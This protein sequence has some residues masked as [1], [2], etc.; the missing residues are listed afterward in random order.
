MFVESAIN[1]WKREL[2]VWI[3]I[4]FSVSYPD[5]GS[6]RAIMLLNISNFFNKEIVLRVDCELIEL[7]SMTVNSSEDNCALN[8]LE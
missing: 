1:S 5:I 6:S 7:N 4:S 2:I 8:I 3:T